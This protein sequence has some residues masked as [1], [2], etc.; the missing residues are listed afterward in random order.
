MEWTDIATTLS[1]IGALVLAVVTFVWSVRENR[2][3]GDAVRESA[4]AAAASAKAA[5]LST[6]YFRRMADA[7]EA[8][9]TDE[10]SRRALAVA[11][12][13]TPR[14]SWEVR[15]VKGATFELINAG[16]G[17][18]Y[19]VEVDAEHAVRFDGPGSVAHWAPGVGRQILA[20]GSLQ[21]GIPQV[22]VR[23]RNTPV[24][25]VLQE[26]TRLLPKA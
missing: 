15:P 4:A 17:S 24:D 8:A 3:T 14:P 25:P 22:R 10:D 18:A 23:W 7:L 13:P 12:L 11:A 9:L 21:T 20:I 2:K 5:E 26:W 19:E 6:E 1:A 16:T